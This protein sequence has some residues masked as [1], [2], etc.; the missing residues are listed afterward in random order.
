M[1]IFKAYERSPLGIYIIGNV[2]HANTEVFNLIK[3]CDVSVRIRPIQ[4]KF[5]FNMLSSEPMAD[6]LPVPF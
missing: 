3:T 6:I 1:K 5:G 4:F 2:T